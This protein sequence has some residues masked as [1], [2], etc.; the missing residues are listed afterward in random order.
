MLV[1]LPTY[2]A[3]AVAVVGNLPKPLVATKADQQSKLV[4]LTLMLSQQHPIARA[5]CAVVAVLRFSNV[6]LQLA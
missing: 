5:D 2:T 6:T 4:R 3:A 1:T